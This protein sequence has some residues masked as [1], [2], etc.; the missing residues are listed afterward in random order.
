MALSI[1]NNGEAKG[2]LNWV[3]KKLGAPMGVVYEKVVG[4]VIRFEEKMGPF[5]TNLEALDPA[6]CKML[7]H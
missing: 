4:K 3:L 2:A 5:E 1:E 7:P 6:Q